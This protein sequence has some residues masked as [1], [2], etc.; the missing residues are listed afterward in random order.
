[1]TRPRGSFSLPDRE[2]NVSLR[3]AL[4]R[5]PLSGRALC[6]TQCRACI[7]P[8]NVRGCGS[9]GPFYCITSGRRIGVFCRFVNGFDSVFEVLTLPSD[10]YTEYV[11]ALPGAAIEI[12]SSWEEAVD[13][14][15]SA[16]A[17]GKVKLLK[18]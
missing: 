11:A 7:D 18:V 10:P 13:T 9:D 14:F 17:A 6:C 16:A 2:P 3:D 15:N 12:V 8:G 1:M 5:P 4:V